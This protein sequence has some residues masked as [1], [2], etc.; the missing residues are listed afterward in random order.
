MPTATG[1]LDGQPV[2]V[3]RDSGCNTVVVKRSLVPGKSFTGITRTVHLLDGS[4]RHLP[5]ARVYIDSP[6]FRGPTLALCMEK[7][8]Y[9]VVLGNIDGVVFPSGCTTSHHLSDVAR[10]HEESAP[11]VESVRYSSVSPDLPT[12]SAATT[13]GVRLPD[14]AAWRTMDDEERRVRKAAASRARRQDPE[15]RAREAAAKRAQQ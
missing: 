8:L 2:T 14:R 13:R 15:V 6:F 11:A 7:P 1:Y 10:L 4:S 5:E 3:L 12:L 9:D